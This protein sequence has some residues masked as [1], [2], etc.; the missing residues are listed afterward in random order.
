MHQN[1]TT[2]LTFPIS[3][4]KFSVSMSLFSCLLLM[5]YYVC[6]NFFSAQRFREYCYFSF[7]RFPNIRSLYDNCT[8]SCAKRIADICLFMQYFKVQKKLPIFQ[9][10]EFVR[11]PRRFDIFNLNWKKKRTTEQCGIVKRMNVLYLVYRSRMTVILSRIAS[12]GTPLFVLYI[13]SP[14][15]FLP[16]YCPDDP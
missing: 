2:F 10:C 9:P 3:S 5:I 8:M 14:L 4:D 12:C 11:I 6:F 15:C 13:F 16:Y 7:K 1:S